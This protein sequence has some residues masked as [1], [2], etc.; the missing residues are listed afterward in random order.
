M[1]CRSLLRVLWVVVALMKPVDGVSQGLYPS[2]GET[3][4]EFEALCRRLRE[5]DNPYYGV[6]LVEKARRRV[7]EQVADPMIASARLGLLGWHHMRMGSNEEAVE[8][9]EEALVL[10]SSV[11]TDEA[12]D[13]ALELRSLLALAHLQFA[14]DLNCLG[15]HNSASCILPMAREGVHQLPEHAKVAG[16]L[17]IHLHLGPGE[18]SRL[19]A[20]GTHL[21][22]ALKEHGMVEHTVWLAEP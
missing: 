7:E 15:F 13:L 8:S 11:D 17:S 4:R 5:S 21:A 10:A 1:D 12:G 9:L 19:S 14:E 2:V 18:G 16:D 20:L 3:R 6:G 22:G